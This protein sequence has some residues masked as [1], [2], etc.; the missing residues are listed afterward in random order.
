MSY[1]VIQEVTSTST[2]VDIAELTHKKRYICATALFECILQSTSSISFISSSTKEISFEDAQMLYIPKISEASSSPLKSLALPL[3]SI[4]KT[5]TYQL[6]SPNKKYTAFYT[7]TGT[8]SNRNARTYWVTNPQTHETYYFVEPI[9]KGWDLVSDASRIF[10]WNASSTKLVYLSDR[11]GYPQLQVI[12]F[13]KK[14]ST[15]EGEPLITRNYTVVD[16]IVID[17]DVYFIANRENLFTYNLYRLSLTTGNLV[18]KVADNVMYTNALTVSN[19]TLLF[20]LNKNGVGMLA[21]YSIPVKT[22]TIFEGI[23]YGELVATSS[24]RITTPFFGRFSQGKQTS[25]QAIIW[26]HGGPY[27]Q[28]ADGRHSWGSYAM[29]DWM[30]EEAN[31]SGVAVLKLDYPGSYGYGSTYANSL[32]EHIGTKDIA[33]L[34]QAISYLTTKGYTSITLFGV[35]YGGYLALKGAVEFPK[36]INN[37][38]AI[39]PVTDWDV[40]IQQTYPTLFD[41]HFNATDKEKRSSQISTSN[42]VN[43]LS[44][45]TPLITLIQGNKDTNVPF[46]Q[47]LYFM[48]QAAKHGLSQ[49]KIKLF[50]LSEEN[51]VFKDPSHIKTICE[52]LKALTASTQMSCALTQ[53]NIHVV[54]H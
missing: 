25:K 54:L 47:S 35:S 49:E 26:L 51:H 9:S 11:R 53:S 29:Y 52:N 19:Q 36:K 50:M 37:V 20:S 16:F 31:K 23:S 10:S 24:R 18:E 13:T 27:R 4:P 43:K 45:S 21:G 7:T 6:E 15:L 5:S 22:T 3:S 48:T 12:D 42:I 44:T 17:N 38:L 28:S 41:V 14:I 8:Y 32:V 2:V 39:A 34:N 33:S 40:L 46:E 30:L 1:S